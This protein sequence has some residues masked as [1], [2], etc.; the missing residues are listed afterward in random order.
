MKVIIRDLHSSI[1]PHMEN[2][3]VEIIIKSTH[4]QNKINCMV[5]EK[6]TKNCWIQTLIMWNSQ[7]RDKNLLKSLYNKLNH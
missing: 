2:S 3:W 1:L 6:E 5:N 4:T 7:Y